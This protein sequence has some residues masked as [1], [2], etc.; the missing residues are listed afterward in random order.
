VESVF[1]ELPHERHNVGGEGAGGLGD[2]EVDRAALLEGVVVVAAALVDASDAC[3]AVE[4]SAAAALAQAERLLD[5]VCACVCVCV[6]YSHTTALIL[7]QHCVC[8]CVLDTT[9]VCVC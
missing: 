9:T 6:K 2:K 7:Q 8:V 5:C 3:G 4:G 1:T